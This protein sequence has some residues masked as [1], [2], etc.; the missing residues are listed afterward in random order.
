VIIA[1][2]RGPPDYLSMPL[3]IKSF[4]SLFEIR[5]QILP[6]IAT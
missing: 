6:Q 4:L 2:G 5:S 3:F 1:I